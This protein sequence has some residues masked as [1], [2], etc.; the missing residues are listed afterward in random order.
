MKTHSGSFREILTNSIINGD[1]V[2][3]KYLPYSLALLL[4]AA[5]IVLVLTGNNGERELDQRVT[6]RRQDKIPYGSY[7]AFNNLPYLFPRA[8]IYTDRREPGYWDSLSIYNANQAFIVISN[9]FFASE[10]ELKKLMTFVEHGNDVF[11]STRYFSAAADAVFHCNSS[12]YD[13]SLFSDEVMAD[14]LRI[15]LSEPPFEQ[16]S[17]YVY[18]GKKFDSYFDKI[19]SSATRVLGFDES[20][21]ANFI[22]LRAGKGNFYLHMEPLAFSNY[23]LLH[24][25]N[26]E[27]YEKVLS[28]IRPEITRVVWDEYYL[29]KRY[30]ESERRRKGWMAVLFSYPALKAAMLTAIFTLLLYVLIEMRR[31]QRF[32]PLITRTRNETLEFVKT[33]GRLYYD[34]GDHKN[35]CRKMAAYFLEH[36]R[37]RYKLAPASLGEDFVKNLQFKTGCPEAEIRGIVSYIKWL[38]ET[39]AVNHLQ[40]IQFHKQLEAFYKKT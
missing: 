24:K 2:L 36:V 29:N 14:S 32:I 5:I 22:H 12:S 20:G 8:T 1:S 40:L 31:K 33:I 21:R 39:P 28:M 7:V 25:N 27:Y 16:A 10:S 35:L 37:N 26:M 11:I 23:F 13:L 34:K 38:D 18:P 15:F 9:K 4:S 17:S 19:D 6:L 30:G 3:K